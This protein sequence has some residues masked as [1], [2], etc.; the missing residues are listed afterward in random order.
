MTTATQQTH[1]MP[2]TADE[3][4]ISTGDRLWW[5][6]LNNMM[7]AR[8]VTVNKIDLDEGLVF[9]KDDVDTH[10][11]TVPEELTTQQPA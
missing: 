6:D 3:K 11:M 5:Q 8:W 7:P 9:C 4:V 1:W 10:L 2:E